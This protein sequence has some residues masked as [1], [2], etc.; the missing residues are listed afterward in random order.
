MSESTSRREFLKTS[1]LGL[2]AAATTMT[3]ASP[4]VSAA[5]RPSGDIA[6][7]ITAGDQ[8]L[9]AGRALRWQSP[10][11]DPSA[12]VVELDPTKTFQDVLGFGASFTDAACFTFNRL[13]T[14]ERDALFRELFAPSELGLSVCRTCVGSSDYATHL[15]SYA[16]GD[17]DPELARFSIAHDREYILPLLRRARE[18]NPDL[19]LLASPWSPP[20]WMK[21]NGSMLGGSMRKKYLP[22]YA[23]YILKFLQG[24]AAEGVPIQALTPQNEVDTDQDGRM[25][26]CLWGQEYEIA[27]VRD[28]LGPL[29]ART[30]T[31]TKIWILDHNYNLWGRVLSQLEDPEF[32]KYVDGVAWHGYVGRPEMMARVSSAH[33]DVTMYWTEGG[34]DYTDS[35]YQTGWGKW[36]ATFAGILRNGCRSITAWNFALDESGRPNIGPFPCGGLV[37]IHSETREVVRSGQYW[38]LAHYARAIRRG[39]RRFESRGATAGGPQHAAFENPGGRRVVVLSNPG[40]ARGVELRLAGRAARLSLPAN[41]MATLAW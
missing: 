12:A 23:Q 28:H 40:D 7:W 17:A 13:A 18:V 2:G 6:V 26:A 34:P 15:Y 8:R 9:A 41:A 19:F 20:G 38:A 22:A 4:S 21:A 24:Y 16:D 32:R 11:T 5:E 29:L 27:F 31:P 39:A 33:P 1:T 35:D 30:G 25:A 36:G 3:A 37:T 10:E 14:A